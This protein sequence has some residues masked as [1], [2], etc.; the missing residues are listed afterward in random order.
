MVRVFPREKKQMTQNYLKNQESGGADDEYT[1]QTARYTEE[2]NKHRS[3]ETEK[4]S[5]HMQS[6]QC[7]EGRSQ[8]VV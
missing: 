3:I 5:S 6:R 7:V 2:A 4:T 1:C 8:F